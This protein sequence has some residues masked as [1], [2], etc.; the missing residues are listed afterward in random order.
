MILFLLAQALVDEEIVAKGYV[1]EIDRIEKPLFNVEY[2]EVELNK[3]YQQR[4]F[5]EGVKRY[6]QP[7]TNEQRFFLAEAYY[8]LKS[9]DRA[10]SLYSLLREDERFGKYATIGKAWIMYRKQLYS[11]AEKLLQDLDT[12]LLALIKFK[13]GNYSK[14]YL[15]ASGLNTPEGL[16]IA[17]VSAYN[18]SNFDLALSAFQKLYT[19]HPSSKFVPYALLR[20]AQIYIRTNFLDDAVKY[21]K[22]LVDNYRDF[23]LRDVALYTLIY[24]LYNTKNVGMFMKYA[25]IFLEDYPRHRYL[26]EVKLMLKQVYLENSEYVDVP[27]RYENYLK[28]YLNFANERF[29]VASEYYRR[30]VKE[31]ERKFLFITR[32]TENPFLNDAFL[33]L[34][35]SLMKLKNYDEAIDYLKKCKTSMCIFQ[36][37][38][39][40]YEKGDYTRSVR[41]LRKLANMDIPPKL[42]ADAYFYIG[43][44]YMKLG[45]T[46][47]K[48]DYLN[49]ALRLYMEAGYEGEADKVRK[50]LER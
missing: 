38:V 13:T 34:G 26:D 36:L 9:Y 21:L 12:L 41:T 14:A 17:G 7:K 1:Q 45:D 43:L 28:G 2:D 4:K 33:E 20:I 39:A 47:K 31:N 40:Y 19:D 8:Y 24:N 44:N 15:L 25:F 37:G 35:I 16:F 48:K 32:Y 11:E 18:L 27:E 5:K 10:D 29:A 50:F 30:F 49:R 6:K 3:L 22:L 42:M 46:E 23:H